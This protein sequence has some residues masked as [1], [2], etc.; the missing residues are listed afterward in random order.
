MDIRWRGGFAAAGDGTADLPGAG[1]VADG[2]QQ[3][4]QA[5][6]QKVI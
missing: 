1:V 4:K 6:W 3:T 2:K 5:G